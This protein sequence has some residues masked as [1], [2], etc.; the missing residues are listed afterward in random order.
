[1]KITELHFYTVNS[2]D[3]AIIEKHHISDEIISLLSQYVD[4]K[5]FSLPYPF[6]TYRVLLDIDRESKQAIFT[7][8]RIEPKTVTPEPV[9]L[10]TNTVVA[11]EEK[12]SA[13]Y[14]ILEFY[15][16]VYNEE[17]PCNRYKLEN[18]QMPC[19]YTMIYPFIM[20]GEAEWLAD[21]EKCLAWTII[22]KVF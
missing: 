10:S 9:P 5:D 11:K 3:M 19:L 16:K 1:M 8:F 21:F 18:D 7:V 15:R 2:G 6:E 14:V 12:Y 4:K 22:E 20:P 17:P 13:V